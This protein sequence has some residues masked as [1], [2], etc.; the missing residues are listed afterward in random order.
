MLEWEPIQRIFPAQEPNCGL[1]HRRLLLHQLMSGTPPR[2]QIS[3]RQLP[4]TPTPEESRAGA[5][6]RRK[7]AITVHRSVSS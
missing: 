5:G 4:P 3:T 6:I 1:L 2:V 7:A